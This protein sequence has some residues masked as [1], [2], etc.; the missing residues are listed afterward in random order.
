MKDVLYQ[1]DFSISMT[2]VRHLLYTRFPE[3][4]AL[5]LLALSAA[6]ST[7]GTF[8]WVT[9]NWCAYPINPLVVNLL[10]K[11]PTGHR[12]WVMD[13]QSQSPILLR[14][15]RLRWHTLSNGALYDCHRVRSFNIKRRPDSV[16]AKSLAELMD[17]FRKI[18]V[19]SKH[20]QNHRLVV[21]TE[22]IPSADMIVDLQK[23]SH[24]A[25]RCL[26]WI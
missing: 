15:A 3:Y 16:L 20:S 13:C 18:S 1:D 8:G 23:I 2:L 9:S 12:I 26:S 24:L 22:G 6:G 5:L 7:T 4:S 10:A 14:W 25:W 17:A 21:T 11:K 19:T